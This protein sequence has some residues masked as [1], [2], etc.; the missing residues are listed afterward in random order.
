MPE[1]S[2]A[3]ATATTRSLELGDL[4][5]AH[6]LHPQQ[7]D[8]DQLQPVVFTRGD[9]VFL[10]D[11]DGRRYLDGIS[12]LWNVNVGH[13]RRE[14]AEA[15]AKQMATLAFANNYVGYSNEPAIRLAS[16]LAELAP[17]DLQ[18]VFFTTGGAESNESA[19]KL[20][21][22]YWSVQGRPQ[23]GKIISRLGGYHGVG[24]G[25]MAATGLPAY[26]SHFGPL[27]SGFSQVAAMSAPALEAQILKEGPET[28]AA[29]IA[30]PV[31]GV[32]GVYPPPADYFRQVR[33]ICDRYDV[34]FIADEV[35]TGFGRTG[36]YWGLDHWNVVPDIIAFAKG[37]TS[38]YL[39]LG[40]MIF[41]DRI[42]ALLHAHAGERFMHAY[43]YSGHPAC[44]AVG[45]RNLDIIEEEGLVERAATSGARLLHNLTPLRA[46]PFVS[47]VRG[48]GMMAAV[49]FRT[50]SGI[51][52]RAFLEARQRGL[53]TRYREESLLLAP[54]LIT[55]D[56]ELDEMTDILLAAVTAVA[57]D[58]R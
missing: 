11:S 23:K 45:L 33:A 20:A 13:G 2:S 46:Q 1:P 24:M 5:R 37:V 22:F 54:P 21:R 41:S 17:G 16:R 28:V 34:L 35:I 19:F 36:R 38:G 3:L 42:R 9:G 8:A 4:D 25:A 55:S 50:G 29:F 18:H 31:M 32:A 30:E 40:G 10:W 12:C 6:Q 27:P 53:M 43:T 7:F 49:E 44:C 48:L 47:E 51:A 56:A 57:A 58:T 39:P 14:L 15:G 26:W 52:A